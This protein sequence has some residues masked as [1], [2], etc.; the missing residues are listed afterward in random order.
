MIDVIN[1]YFFAAMLLLFTVDWHYLEIIL[2]EL[3]NINPFMFYLY[4]D[5]LEQ[6][7][8]YKQYSHNH[9]FNLQI[10]VQIATITS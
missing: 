4:I 8:Y 7:S 5:V 3:E 6:L 1:E 2:I 10:I 9:F